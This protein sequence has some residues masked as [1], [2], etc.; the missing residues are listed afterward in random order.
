MTSLSFKKVDQNIINKIIDDNQLFLTDSK[1]PNIKYLIKTKNN[2]TISIYTT[3]TVLIQGNDAQLFALKYNLQSDINVTKPLSLELPNIGCDEVGVGDFFGPL[4][5]CCA[6][7]NKDFILNYP[8]LTNSITDSKK[9]NDLK[10]IDLFEQLKDKVKWEVYILDNSKYNKAYDIYKNTHILKAICHNQALKRLFRNNNEL[11]GQQIIM[12]QFVDKKNYYNYLKDQ[13]VVI[14]DI[15]FETKAESKY[16]SVAIA[17]IIARFHFLKE[18]EKLEKEFN[19]KLPLGASNNVKD[20]VNTYKKEFP[21]EVTKFI[22]LH[23]NSN[24]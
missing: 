23:F 24:K 4:I 13:E 15:Y 19:I 17:S 21:L 6:Y 9:I 10:I 8:E 5:T 3:N 2:L 22:K 11:I 12:D 1:N 18:I 20:Y 16:I 14:E 7:V